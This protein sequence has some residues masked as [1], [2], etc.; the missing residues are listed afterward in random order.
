MYTSMR[1]LHAWHARTMCVSEQHEE[2]CTINIYV[3]ACKTDNR[4]VHMCIDARAHSHVHT[5]NV[6][7]INTRAA[8]NFVVYT[9]NCTQ[10]HTRP[11]TCIHTYTR[12]HAHIHAHACST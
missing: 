5:H 8:N 1:A 6:T 12:F 3:F 10:S 7:Q 9:Q 4:Q 11:H 2:K